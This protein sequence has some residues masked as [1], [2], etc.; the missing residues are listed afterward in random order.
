MVVR[1]QTIYHETDAIINDE[2]AERAKKIDKLEQEN[3]YLSEA[4]EIADR[5]IGISELLLTEKITDKLLLRVPELIPCFKE[6]PDV[7]YEH[8]K[9]EIPKTI[10][11]TDFFKLAIPRYNQAIKKI[12]E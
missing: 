12:K 9:L 10:S 6:M 8:H 3:K 11:V 1:S 4:K 5:I 7:Y 2:L